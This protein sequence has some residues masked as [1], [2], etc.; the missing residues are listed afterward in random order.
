MTAATSTT[1]L[2]T[3]FYTVHFLA[4]VCKTVVELSG[5]TPFITKLEDIL[6]LDRH[7]VN[8][9]PMLAIFIGARLRALQV[10]SKHGSPLRVKLLMQPYNVVQILAGLYMTKVQLVAAIEA[11]N[12][13]EV[14]AAITMQQMDLKPE[15][16]L[17]QTKQAG[18]I[19][20]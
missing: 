17:F 5:W 16:F 13:T 10:D 12:F 18:E 2:T 9:A 1:L 11:G 7:V 4:V 19:I 8:F 6:G 14:Q 15:D 20:P 3:M